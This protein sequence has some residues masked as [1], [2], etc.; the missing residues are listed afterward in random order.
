MMDEIYY[1]SPALCWTAILWSETG[2]HE[3]FRGVEIPEEIEALLDQNKTYECNTE[4]RGDALWVTEVG[5]VIA[6]RE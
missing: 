6:E 1:D 2:Y 5:G 3:E 4:L